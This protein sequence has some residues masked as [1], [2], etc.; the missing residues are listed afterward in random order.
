MWVS[1]AAS[2]AALQGAFLDAPWAALLSSPRVAV[3]GSLAALRAAL[4]VAAHY[5]GDVVGSLWHRGHGHVGGAAGI[6]EGAA[7]V[8]SRAEAADLGA[9]I[10]VKHPES[11][12][13]SINSSRG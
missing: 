13:V 8:F 9:A 7:G 5:I 6:P 12:G 1:L 3:R 4:F 10:Q 11:A 2:T